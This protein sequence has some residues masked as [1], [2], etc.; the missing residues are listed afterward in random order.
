MILALAVMSAL[1]I[2]QT[3]REWLKRKVPRI[4]LIIGH[5]IGVTSVALILF[6]V[7]RM[8]DGPLREAIVWT[9][10]AYVTIVMYALF[11]ATVRYFAFGVARHFKHKKVLRILSSQA[12]FFTA[13]LIISVAYMIP[14]VHNATTLKTAAYNV[15]VDKACDDEAL[16]VA[17]VADFHVGAG[18][19]HSELGQM[20][21]LLDE[22]DPDLI[23]IAGDIS[24]SGSSVYDLEY[25]ES[26][27]KEL[28]PRYGIYYAEGNHEKE[29][30][31]DPAP[32]LQGAGV[33]ILK[34]EGILLENGVNLIGR[35]NALQESAEQIMEESGLDASAPTIVFQHRPRGLSQ[36]DGVADLAICAHTHGYCYPFIGISM[37]YVQDIIY[38]QRMYGKT[39]VVV[40]SG[41]A[42]WGY[43]TKWPSQSE[44]TIVNMNFKEAA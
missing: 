34:D 23:L 19:R 9:E 37:P 1:T 10:T 40:T 30:R 2:L 15:Q 39:N 11:M 38:G 20:K 28:N 41:V 14:A 24:D 4:L 13:V 18:A 17:V 43:R 3:P 33:T 35:K 5:T 21:K 22:A 7:W 8:K 42:E 6:V 25:M 16:S 32:Y 36:L 31:V 29:C 12:A 27:L 44:I 26:V